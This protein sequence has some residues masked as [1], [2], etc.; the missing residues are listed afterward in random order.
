MKK[1]LILIFFI[2]NFS[3]FAQEEFDL[4]FFLSGSEVTDISSFGNEIWFATNGNGLFRYLKKENKWDQFSTSRGNLQHDFFYCVAANNEFI[5]AGS[6]DGLFIYEKKRNSWTKRKFGLGGQLSNWIRSI[7]YDEYEKAVWIGRFQYL[8]KFDEKTKRFTDYN[9]TVKGNQKTNT[10]KTIRVDGDSLVWFG[11]EAGLHKYNKSKDLNNPNS[12]TF[13]DNRFNYFNGEG[14]Q[15]SISALLTERNN[16]WIGLD[17]FIT[18]ERPEFNVGGLFRFNRRNDWVRFDG[19]KG[20]TGNGIHDIE[21]TGNFIWASVYQFGKATKEVYGRGLVLINRL[22]NQVIPIRDERIP[23]SVNK[24]F[25]DGIFLWL[26]SDKGLAKINFFNQ[27][28]QW[29]KGEK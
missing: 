1:I 24:I 18:A 16:L 10:I 5:W 2:I 29:T 26:A 9:L 11:T 19:S 3:V 23:Q 4:D 21:L 20:L 28:A 13:Y 8:T 6:I 7:K 27:L 12:I 15:V 22:T 14:E 25:F 17:E